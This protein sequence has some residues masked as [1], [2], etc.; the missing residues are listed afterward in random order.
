MNKQERMDNSIWETY[1]M[2]G[3]ILLEMGPEAKAYRA[4]VRSGSEE[5][6]KLIGQIPVSAKR[7]RQRRTLD[8]KQGYGGAAADKKARLAAFRKAEE[9][10]ERKRERQ[11]RQAYGDGTGKTYQNITQD[12]DDAP[13]TMTH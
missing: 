4:A 7:V 10:A 5:Q 3:A 2:V 6:T 13:T 8:R 11:R 9:A 12:D 1:R